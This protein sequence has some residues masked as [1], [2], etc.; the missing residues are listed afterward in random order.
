MR[1]RKK[2]KEKKNEAKKK[3]KKE[4]KCLLVKRYQAIYSDSIH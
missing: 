3:D 1:E 4:R 2:R